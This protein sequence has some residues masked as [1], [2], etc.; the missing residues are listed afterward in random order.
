MYIYGSRVADT[1]LDCDVQ[2][3]DDDCFKICTVRTGLCIFEIIL[4]S[5]EVFLNIQ[6]RSLYIIE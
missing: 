6:N 2:V 1:Q 3:S 5:Y 4:M